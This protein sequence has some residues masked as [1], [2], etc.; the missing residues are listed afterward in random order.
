[1]S[2]TKTVKLPGYENTIFPEATPNSDLEF[3]MKLLT[4]IIFGLWNQKKNELAKHGWPPQAIH[5]NEIYAEYKARVQRYKTMDEKLGLRKDR[6]W[7]IY[8]KVHTHNWIERRVNYLA[9]EKFGPKQNGIL[10]IVNV[11]KGEYAPNPQLFK[12]EEG[13]R[14]ITK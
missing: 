13:F 4:Q 2:K 7:P 6:F 5:Q 10:K 3:H 11:T 1:M 14:E 8:A 9:T 12:A